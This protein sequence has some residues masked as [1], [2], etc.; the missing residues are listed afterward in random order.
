M[1]ANAEQKFFST[2]TPSTYSCV[3][4]DQTKTIEKDSDNTVYLHV[5]YGT[6]TKALWTMMKKHADN[7]FRLIAVNTFFW[8]TGNQDE[9]EY[10]TECGEKYQLSLVNDHAECKICITM[11]IPMS[12]AALHEFFAWSPSE[13][14]TIGFLAK[15]S[16]IAKAEQDVAQKYTPGTLLGNY[17]D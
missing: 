8:E 16:H 7:C 13:P 4:I 14:Q 17:N 2:L 3:E 11:R 1:Q 6:N 12:H 15:L 9:R 5:T 10:T